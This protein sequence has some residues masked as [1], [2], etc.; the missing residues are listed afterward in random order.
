[1]AYFL[2]GL[3]DYYFKAAGGNVLT[4]AMPI[5]CVM[6][7]PY[8]NWIQEAAL[9][10]QVVYFYYNRMTATIFEELLLKV[11]LIVSKNDTHLLNISRLVFCCNFSKFFFKY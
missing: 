6:Y 11:G 3:P 5:E 10:G 2:P 8:F 7:S 1:V 4:L 9:H